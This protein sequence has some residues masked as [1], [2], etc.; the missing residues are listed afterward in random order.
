MLLCLHTYANLGQS[1]S[2]C[3]SAGGRHEKHFHSGNAVPALIDRPWH[4]YAK[5]TPPH[6][7]S[8]L[9]VKW[10]SASR[11][12][13]EETGSSSQCKKKRGNW[14][15][16][17]KWE[18]V[19]LWRHTWRTFLEEEALP[20][21]KRGLE[22]GLNLL[23]PTSEHTPVSSLYKVAVYLILCGCVG[24]VWPCVAAESTVMSKAWGRSSH[25]MSIRDRQHEEQQGAIMEPGPRHSSLKTKQMCSRV[26]WNICPP[27]EGKMEDL[28]PFWKA[29]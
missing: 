3:V 27:A 29:L 1:E 7:D 15:S 25:T 8:L 16:Q 28:F 9:P 23:P 20:W 17:L 12:W 2:A 26:M 22:I 13:A 5:L 18:K 21:K 19:A 10:S 6:T 24:R 14:I 11:K 4:P